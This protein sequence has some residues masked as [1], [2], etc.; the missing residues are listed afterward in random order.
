MKPSIFFT[1]CGAFLFDTIILLNCHAQVTFERELGVREA[2]EAIR[3]ADG[4]YFMITAVTVGNYSNYGIARLD[5]S[6]GLTNIRIKDPQNTIYYNDLN[7]LRRT[8]SG[9]A[10][11]G[12]EGTTNLVL[13][14]CT[15]HLEDRKI[16]LLAQ[17]NVSVTKF[18]S[19]SDNGYA[20][21]AT[22]EVSPGNYNI[23]IFRLDADANILWT[24][25]VDK[26]NTLLP[27][28]IYEA[29]NSDLVLVATHDADGLI[30]RMAADGTPV[31]E[32]HL[33][34]T[35]QLAVLDS[36]FNNDRLYVLGTTGG[37]TSCELV[38][39]DETGAIA[40]RDVL[41][42]KSSAIYFETTFT[43]ADDGRL[44][45]V[46]DA[47]PGKGFNL[48]LFDVSLA[49]EKT[50][51][52]DRATSYDGVT[53]AKSIVSAPDGFFI[54][55]TAPDALAIK[56]D[57]DGGTG[58]PPPFQEVDDPGLLTDHDGNH[59]TWIDVGND[60]KKE[61]IVANGSVK[62]FSYDDATGKFQEAPVP[63]PGDLADTHSFSICDF[64][65]DGAM[66]LYA[67]RYATGVYGGYFARP[68]ILFENEGDGTFTAITGL[69]INDPAMSTT[70]SFWVDINNDGYQDLFTA[71][72]ERDKAYLNNGDG[73]FRDMTPESFEEKT[74]WIYSTH[75][76]FTDLNKDG[77]IDY[78]AT[79]NLQIDLMLNI[80][81]QR[82]EKHALLEFFDYSTSYDMPAGIYD[83]SP[84]YFSG[85]KCA[86]LMD[87]KGSYFEHD[88]NIY[89][90][91]PVPA[92]LVN[93]NNPTKGEFIDFE[94][95]GDLDVYLNG[96]NSYDITTHLFHRN[97]SETGFT[98]YRSFS[99]ERF[100]SFTFYDA[101]ANGAPDMVGG[102]GEVKFLKNTSGNNWLT[103]ALTG[104]ILTRLGD[105]AVVSVKANGKWTHQEVTTHAGHN[106]K[107][108]YEARFG[109]NESIVADSVCTYWPSGC[110]TCRTNVSANQ[111]LLIEEDCSGAAPQA[112]HKMKLCRGESITISITSPGSKFQWFTDLTSPA[113]AET[114]SQ[115]EIDTLTR[116]TS[117]FVANADSAWLSRRIPIR[118]HV[119]PPPEFTILA[120]QAGNSLE[121]AIE[122]ASE[123]DAFKWTVNDQV[124]SNTVSFAYPFESSG[125]LTICGE[126]VFEGCVSTT[127][128]ETV[129]TAVEQT[130]SAYG[131]Y[132]NPFRHTFVVDGTVRS[133]VEV[134]TTQGQSVPVPCAYRENS[135]EVDMTGYPQGIYFV[136]VNAWKFVK[137]R[138][139]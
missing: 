137:V 82:F 112:S 39:I 19:L 62:M 131:A 42:T 15:D 70:Q 12:R 16:S 54:T 121:L 36:K 124:A 134:F 34:D 58:V 132:P 63:L 129:V 99:N 25:D 9:I 138:K 103:V 43:L 10:A 109:L 59:Y 72:I 119:T 1:V 30:I 20:V 33:S 110:V 128:I 94:N 48:M 40:D 53:R 32:K 31:W 60:G 84:G 21:A 77:Y 67:D 22:F 57:N 18:E 126:A 91:K 130:Q 38:Q 61:L 14:T 7:D 87:G 136:K 75:Y 23:R 56:T 123:I 81:G 13:F 6:G 114:G 24:R 95:D 28:D 51:L 74:D 66:D 29:S 106:G 116:S 118:I 104:N 52:F 47:W 71:N 8:S 3:D 125:L 46:T 26:I 89:R 80:E 120:G 69:N 2:T 113:I 98:R 135:V 50:V 11:I 83:F 108:E 96:S 139:D 102:N 41:F 111:R 49:H 37:G 97:D 100:R 101:D 55:A 85:R 68:N 44:A 105:G 76:A 79:Q 86:V 4:N 78:I 17:G 27:V 127:C 73:T 35:D 107:V 92:G 5:P 90:Q 65:N 117:L 93:R 133:P 88:G 64:N 122:T 115:V 45:V